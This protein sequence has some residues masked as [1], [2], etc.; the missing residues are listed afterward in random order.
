MQR[1]R[2]VIHVGLVALLAILI[3]FASPGLRAA[4]QNFPPSAA[5]PTSLNESTVKALQEALIRQGIPVAVSGT[6]NE[7]TRAA[8]K[9]FQ[10]RHHLPVTGEPDKAT[11][12]KLGVQTGAGPTTPSTVAQA[13]PSS[14]ATPSA[15]PSQPNA[16]NCPMMQDQMAAMM[17]MMQGM[18]QMMQTVQSQMQPGQ[19]QRG[20]M[21]PGGM[22]PG[23]R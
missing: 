15:Q 22:Q 7:E 4:A 2:R 13:A 19:M 17:Q 8:V 16:M 6:L 1:R 3:Q 21:M 20:Q 18:M 5:A 9:T 23:S 14:P 11:L 10:G 12:D